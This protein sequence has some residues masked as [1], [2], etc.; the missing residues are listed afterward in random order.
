MVSR[1]P[2]PAPPDGPTPATPTP[3]PPDDIEGVAADSMV[4]EAQPT[5]AGEQPE[6]DAAA[7]AWG[8]AAESDAFSFGAGA[9]Q[10]QQL[11]FAGSQPYLHGVS[12]HFKKHQRMQVHFGKRVSFMVSKNPSGKEVAGDWICAACKNFNY[13]YRKQCNRCHERQ[14]AKDV[15][16]KKEAAKQ[17]TD[18][19]GAPC[20]CQWSQSGF[21]NVELYCCQLSQNI[22]YHPRHKKESFAIEEQCCAMYLSSLLKEQGCS[23]GRYF[24]P[25]SKKKS[26]CLEY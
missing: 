4:R 6:H 18:G 21:A 5:P 2:A 20:D 11:P 24:F 26:S 16:M 14:T 19:P 9:K 22:N 10:Q 3:A 7:D 13:S 1:T 8:V 12:W 25:N 23:P 17:N 15:W